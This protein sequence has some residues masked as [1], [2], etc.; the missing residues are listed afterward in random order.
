[1]LWFSVQVRA[2]PP[3]SYGLGLCSARNFRSI[4]FR[5]DYEFS[6][7]T[8]TPPKRPGLLSTRQL[9]ESLELVASL[10]FD[11]IEEA[12]KLEREMKAKKN[13]RLALFLMEQRRLQMSG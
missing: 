11:S 10:E 2:G 1:M 3:L 13:P 7:T 5:I 6:S 9:G 4:L 12:Q 8:C